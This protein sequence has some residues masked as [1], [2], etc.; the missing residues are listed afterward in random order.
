MN[1]ST[2][3]QDKIVA[4]VKKVLTNN[5][6]SLKKAEEVIGHLI[7]HPTYDDMIV[8]MLFFTVL[9]LEKPDD[10]VYQN[11]LTAHEMFI[12]YQQILLNE[13]KQAM[14]PGDVFETDFDP[15]SLLDSGVR[16]EPETADSGTDCDETS[17]L[18]FATSK[19]MKQ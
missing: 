10:S 13:L 2:D 8:K 1:L 5:Y 15:L 16:Y 3:T 14:L 18:N 9:Q 4:I 6:C 17:I 12:E 11:C 19:D 7:S